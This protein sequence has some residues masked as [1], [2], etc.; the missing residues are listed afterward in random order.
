MM[1]DAN[2]QKKR[3]RIA[4]VG[5][6]PADQITLKGYFRVLL[7]L[8]AD[9]EWVSATET[10][11]NL[12][13]I[14]HEFKNA[15]SVTKLLNSNMGVP[16]LYIDRVEDGDGGL[17]D[18][19]LTLPLKQVHELN[20]WLQK[21]V[22]VSDVVVS[23]PKREEV[24]SINPALSSAPAVAAETKVL[25][26]NDFVELI[27]TVQAKKASTYEIVDGDNLVAVMDTGKQ[28]V[29][30]SGTTRVSP[31]WRLRIYTGMNKDL[32]SSQ[33]AVQWLWSLIW[34]NSDELVRLISDQQKYH[35]RFW[36]KPNQTDRRDL[37]QIMTA[38]EK[39]SLSPVEV[40]SRAGVSVATAKKAL[41]SLLVAGVLDN[42]AYQGLV[43][44]SVSMPVVE[45]APEPIPEP[46]KA[47]TPT[48]QQEEKLG[49]L[50]RLR[51]KLGL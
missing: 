22:G 27:K 47:T 43:A 36:V 48:P 19:L 11:V 46:P 7:R 15:S 29:W 41:I 2:Q 16:V 44:P 6:R 13:V 23:A 49:F 25:N 45:V 51:R 3:M 21:N 42:D 26:L 50:S 28:L 14:N 32:K 1:G 30:T 8:D 31:N 20:D 18:N 37:L 4:L 10:F 12:F 5:V 34:Q 35:L 38:L 9:L 24:P 33:D 40:A 17:T 39:A